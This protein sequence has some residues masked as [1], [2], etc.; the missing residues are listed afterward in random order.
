MF[1]KAIIFD[2]DNTLYNY[3]I[4]DK[5]SYHN[6]IL[7]IKSKI[8]ISN[9]LILEN[10]NETL[11]MGPGPSLVSPEVYKS[12][13]KFTIGHLDPQFIKIMDTMIMMSYIK[14]IFFQ[15]SISIIIFILYLLKVILL[16]H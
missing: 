7:S 13:S 16:F 5:E 8:N 2:L 14:M 6:V 12:I 9:E 1:I 4:I 3:D 11:L 15:T 10:I